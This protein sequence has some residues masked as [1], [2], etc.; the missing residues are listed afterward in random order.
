MFD[1][2]FYVISNEDQT[3]FLQV[4]KETETEIEFQ[5]TNFFEHAT[6]FFH[7]RIACDGELMA[8]ITYED[9]LPEDGMFE[10]EKFYVIKVNYQFH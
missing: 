7:D 9:C 5:T 10:G 6:Q 8:G 4:T 2:C 3:K 1:G